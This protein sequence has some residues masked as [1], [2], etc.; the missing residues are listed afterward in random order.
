MIPNRLVNLNVYPKF[1]TGRWDQDRD[2]NN[3]RTEE[4]K[5]S[6]WQRRSK[7]FKKKDSDRSPSKHGQQHRDIL[8]RRASGKFKEQPKT[9]FV[10]D[11]RILLEIRCGWTF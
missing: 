3:G 2:V 4:G 6:G 9:A 1:E 7:Y 5:G 10:V 8:A 11:N